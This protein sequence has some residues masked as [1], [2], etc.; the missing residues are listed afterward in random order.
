MT[1]VRIARLR[2]IEIILRPSSRLAVKRFRDYTPLDPPSSQWL[3]QRSLEQLKLI[4]G[5]S[6][7]GIEFQRLLK[8]L[9]RA[10]LV[11]FRVSGL[12]HRL[13]SAGR[14]RVVLQIGLQIGD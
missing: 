8:V 1:N 2:E 6:V 10:W 14:L 9:D 11:A 12:R 13:I 3:S 4:S 5:L 7:P